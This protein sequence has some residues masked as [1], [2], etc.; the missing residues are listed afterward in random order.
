MGETHANRQPFKMAELSR[1]FRMVLDNIDLPIC[2]YDRDLV[3]HFVNRQYAEF[4]GLPESRIGVVEAA[5]PN[6][7]GSRHS[8]PRTPRTR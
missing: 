8:A 2:Y 7:S 1:Q 6:R 5:L 4:L 3:L